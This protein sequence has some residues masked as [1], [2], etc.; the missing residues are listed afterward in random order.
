MIRL[1]LDKYIYQQTIE[2][3]VSLYFFEIDFLKYVILYQV[4]K[5]LRV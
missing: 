5:F 4:I 1:T 3:K 2:R